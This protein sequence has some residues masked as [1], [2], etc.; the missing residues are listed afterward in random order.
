MRRGT[1][2]VLSYK[3]HVDS[4][5]H[6]DTYQKSGK[7]ASQC[8]PHFPLLTFSSHPTLTWHSCSPMHAQRQH[9]YSSPRCCLSTPHSTV[10][11]RLWK[12]T[13]PSPPV[14]HTMQFT[15]CKTVMAY[16]GRVAWG[17]NLVLVLQTKPTSLATNT[18]DKQQP[19]QSFHSL[20][21]SLR[22]TLLTLLFLCSFS[23]PVKFLPHL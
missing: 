22:A 20:P 19:P 12:Q 17:S 13:A 14:T 8:K 10:A 23:D 16:P 2:S 18:C 6:R 4:R 9:P 11:P 21:T 3:L 5:W 7:H 15:S 1:V